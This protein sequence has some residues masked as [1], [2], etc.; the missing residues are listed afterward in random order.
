MNTVFDNDW[1]DI[2]AEEF[3]KDY[4]I[5]LQKFVD[6]EYNITTVYPPRED[7]M[8]AFTTTPYSKVKVVLLGQDPYHGP[9]QAHGLCF[10]VNNGV[11][12][13]PSL[14][15]IFQE[16]QNDMGCPIPKDG[17]LLNWANQGVFLL[18]T[19]LT[20]RQGEAN[21]HKGMGWEKFTD[22]VIKKLAERS[23]PMIFV[24]WGKPAQ[25]KKKIIERVGTHHYILEAPHPSPLSAYRGFFGSKPFSKINGKLVEWGQ[26][27]ID[28]SL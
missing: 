3:E 22:A 15:N 10:S 2:L 21:S 6:E 28:W 14:K 11:P 7:V 1:Q 24:L 18:N 13:P 8:N 20:V 23:Q 5:K 4:F 17:N 12:L 25:S 16:L 27:P 19:V 26:Q 9:E